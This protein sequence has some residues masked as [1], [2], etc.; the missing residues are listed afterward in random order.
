MSETT[1]KKELLSAGAANVVIEVPIAAPASEVWRAMVE[2]IGAWWRGDFLVCEGSLG[3]ALEP[4]VGGL[5]FE[6]SPGGDGCGLAWGQVIAFQPEGIGDPEGLFEAIVEA[7]RAGRV[8]QP[9]LGLMQA[10][11]FAYYTARA[12]GRNVDK[13]RALAKSVTVG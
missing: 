11:L 13:P 7:P 5:L 6:R 10:Q 3:M 4:R 8:A 12:L 9:L 2:D 1:T